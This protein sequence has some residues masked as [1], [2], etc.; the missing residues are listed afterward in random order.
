MCTIRKSS[1]ESIYQGAANIPLDES[2]SY[3][4]ELHFDREIL[5]IYP[6][7]RRAYCAARILRGFEA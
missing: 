1:A 6:S 5:I 3:L 4:G 2:L 7:G